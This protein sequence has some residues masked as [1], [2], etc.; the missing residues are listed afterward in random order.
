MI[1]V[2]R[3]ISRRPIDFAGR[4]ADHSFHVAIPCCLKDVEC[5]RYVCLDVGCGGLIGKWDGYQCWEMQHNVAALNQFTYVM[6]I[7]D[8]ACHNLELA[9]YVRS[10][11][12]QPSP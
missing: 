8:V 9:A 12:I 11:V 2:D 4:R 3:H 10:H 1:F 6:R 5:P 7:S